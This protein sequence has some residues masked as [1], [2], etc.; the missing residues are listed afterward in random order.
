MMEVPPPEHGIHNW[1]DFLVHMGT[2]TLG[3]LIAIGL[4]QSVEWLHHRH[5]LHDL[6]AALEEDTEK[7]IQDS[8]HIEAHTQVHVGWL[9]RR[10]AQVRL[11]ITEKVPIVDL[12]PPEQ[13]APFDLPGAPAWRAAKNGGLLQI[14][15]QP[16]IQA[17]SEVDD[18]IVL[19]DAAYIKHA[20]AIGNRLAFEKEFSGD[21]PESHDFSSATT[22]QLQE[23]MRLLE[24]EKNMYLWWGFWARQ[25]L[26]AEMAIARGERN[27]VKIQAA[28]RQVTEK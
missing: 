4:E 10:E 7:A 12:P 18:L 27:L 23:Y 25:V 1:H 15:S 20:E 19:D 9:R 2:I 13:R 6:H 5:Q 28:E 24:E 8:Q 21:D 22:S 14:I 26:G 17:Y 16:D 11:A 3:L